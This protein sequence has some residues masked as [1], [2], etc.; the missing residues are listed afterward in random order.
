MWSSCHLWSHV[1]ISYEICYLAVAVQLVRTIL[2]MLSDL[3]PEPAIMTTRNASFACAGI[4]LSSAPISINS[5]PFDWRDYRYLSSYGSLLPLSLNLL[6]PRVHPCECGC[7][8]EDPLFP[9]SPGGFNFPA[10]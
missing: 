8:H 7:I 6:C 2:P 1:R 4:H 9:T 3:R 5:I 10:D